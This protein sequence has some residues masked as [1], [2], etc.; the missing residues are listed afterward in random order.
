MYTIYADNE[1]L[2]SPNIQDKKHYVINPKLTVELNKAG[3]LEFKLPPGNVGY[4]SI[5]KLKSV[6]K[7]YCDDQEMWR[8]RVLSSDADFYR[9][10]KLYCEGELAYL[11]DSKVR[12]YQH[13]GGVADYFSYMINQHNNQVD[14]FKRFVVGDVT[15]TDKDNN[16]YIVRA[17]KNYPDT[18]SEVTDK[19]LN[20]L[21]GYLKVRRDGNNR[22]IDYLVESGKKSSQVIQFGVNL[23]DLDEYINAEDV[24]T[25]LIPLG[26]QSEDEAKDRLTIS[27]VNDGKDYIEDETAIKLF[28]RITETQTWD[29]VMVPE[30]LLKK[31]KEYLKAGIEMSVTLTIKAVDLVFLGVDTESIKLGEYI[32]VVSVPHDI[33][34]YFLCSKIVYDLVDPS[35]TEYTLGV[36]FSALTDRQAEA[37]KSST[38]VLQIAEGANA[39]A[40]N[41]VAI[42]ENAK[43]VGNDKLDI[44]DFSEYKKTV[45]NTYAKKTDIPTKLSQMENDTEYIQTK[46]FED[47][48]KRVKALE[49][50]E[51]IE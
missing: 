8:G 18:F 46:D 5:Q 13:S 14:K 28:G 3:S 7:V 22:C 33:D 17:N 45:E 23:L 50:K 27:S 24:F 10:K 32:R 16:D 20:N 9:R 49:E 15:V 25:V 21:G 19:L 1:L 2:Y 26:K 31:G 43:D 12:P 51:I 34:T 36:T 42:A 35:K 39:A 41:A 29:D 44:V 38:K 40:S 4:S 48:E 6:V 30:N 11:L 37:S 47:L